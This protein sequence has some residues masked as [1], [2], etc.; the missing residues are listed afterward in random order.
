[1]DASEENLAITYLAVVQ[2]IAVIA[3][4][5]LNLYPLRLLIYH[6]QSSL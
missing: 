3:Y 1:M 4:L 5:F 2:A 6:W